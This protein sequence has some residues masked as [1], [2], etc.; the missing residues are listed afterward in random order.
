[1]KTNTG[2]VTELVNAELVEISVSVQVMPYVGY[3]SSQIITAV[4]DALNEYLSPNRWDWSDTVRQTEII[5]LI[6]GVEGVSYVDE[7][8][9]LSISSGNATV[10]INGDISFNLLGTLP[11][12]TGHTISVLAP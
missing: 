7:L 1:M 11:V 5:S 9:D 12:S 3:T 4:T 8:S 6:D 2:L 10:D